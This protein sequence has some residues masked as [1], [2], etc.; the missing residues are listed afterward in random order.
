MTFKYIHILNKSA[1]E[2]GMTQEKHQHNFNSIV[3]PLK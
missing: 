1:F 2:A 3:V